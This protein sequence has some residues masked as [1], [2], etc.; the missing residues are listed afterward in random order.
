[1]ESELFDCTV[2]ISKNLQS[3]FIEQNLSNQKLVRLRNPDDIQFSID[4]QTEIVSQFLLLL[5]DYYKGNFEESILR[6]EQIR[7]LP[8][9]NQSS[10][11]KTLCFIY[12]A[13]S[14]LGRNEIDRA[15]SV[16]NEALIDT[17]NNALVH[18]NY[19]QLELAAGDSA[20]AFQ[21]FEIARSMTPD[22]VNPIPTYSQ[23][24]EEQEAPSEGTTPT[25]ATA[26]ANA[27]VAQAFQP[28]TIQE[29]KK[30]T[31]FIDQPKQ[32][33][34]EPKKPKSTF[35]S[36]C[37]V[38]QLDANKYAVYDLQNKK[39]GEYQ[40]IWPAAGRKTNTTVT[41]PLE[42]YFYVR[43]GDYFGVIDN[44]GKIIFRPVFDSLDEVSKAL[45]NKKL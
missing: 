42:N 23:P 19:A 31:T 32:S 39:L 12:E 25:P 34:N 17:L 5:L 13:N 6:A 30:P 29:V 24:T 38:V 43:Q 36:N 18:H 14:Y 2:Y 40:Q 33:A 3:A 26:L 28:D 4:R 20:L 8:N 1:M 16:Y 35:P 37:R 15:R 9:W 7:T 11:V 27:P 21:H 44:S 22:F 45:L 41:D 10:E